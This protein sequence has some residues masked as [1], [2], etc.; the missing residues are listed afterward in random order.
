MELTVCICTHNRPR[1]VKDCLAGLARQTASRNQFTILIVDS[2]STGVAREQLAELAMAD[3]AMRLIRLDYP[4]ISSARNAAAW[5]SRTPFI[6]YI[7]DDAIPAETWVASILRVISAEPRRPALIG[8]RILPRWESPL[9]AWWPASLR[10]VLSIIEAQG[11][12]EYRSN[13]IPHGLEPYAANMVVH[14][15]SLL[16]VGG[17]GTASGRCGDRLLSDEEV[18]VAWKL[19]DAGHS[20]RYESSVVVE[21]Q[22]Q[23][24]RLTPSWLLSRLYWQGASAV[25]TRR[26]LGR[27]ASV[28]RELPRRL[29]LLAILAP[30]H[31]L[32]TASTRLI[33]ARWRLAYAAGF[34]RAAFGWNASQVAS[35][36]AP[37]WQR[38]RRARVLAPSRV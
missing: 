22:I 36:A 18:Q 2:G 31:L 4:G 23:S 14:V 20:I 21:H 8:G 24:S 9:P 15:L 35:G 16:A 28:W 7:D 27:P 19:Q 26:T 1:Y 11:S 34:V 13:E 30:L 37:R 33:G 5:A 6:V 3:P 29:L 38:S 17:F 32:P 12:G 25:V 10:G